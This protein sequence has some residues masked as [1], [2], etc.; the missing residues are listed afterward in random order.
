[1]T[2]RSRPPKAKLQALVELDGR[3]HLVRQA[4]GLQ[5]AITSD[6]GGDLSAAQSIL[7]ERACLIATFCEAC[8]AK[9]LSAPEAGMDESYLSA[10][11]TL[12][13]VLGQL[14][15]E[16]RARDVTPNLQTYLADK[17]KGRAA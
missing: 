16:R 17:A 15:I 5:A 4:R 8:E 11:G 10:V 2:A 6:L 12:R 1:M 3:T 9:W 7:V 14:G 13:H